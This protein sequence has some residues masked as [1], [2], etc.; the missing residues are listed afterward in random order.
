MIMP[1]HSRPNHRVLMRRASSTVSPASSSPTPLSCRLETRN[2]MMGL[3]RR[4]PPPPARRDPDH[5]EDPNPNKNPRQRRIFLIA[6]AVAGAVPKSRRRHRRQRQPGFH[7]AIT[8]AAATLHRTPAS[9]AAH[10]HMPGTWNSHH[11]HHSSRNPAI[12]TIPLIPTK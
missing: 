10:W 8:A 7:H 11:S 3:Y 1:G 12:L 2:R 9:C 5:E 6:I 4:P